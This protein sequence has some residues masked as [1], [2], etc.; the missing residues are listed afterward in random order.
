MCKSLF[1]RLAA[2]ILCHSTCD[3]GALDKTFLLVG[4]GGFVGSVLRYWLA[5]FIG[6]PVNSSFPFGTFTVNI[7]GCLLIGVI[8]GF[9]E[10]GTILSPEI[11]ILL[12]AGFCGGFTTFSAFS[13][14]SIS[15]LREG[16][17]VYVGANVVLSV[18]LGIVSTYIGLLIARSI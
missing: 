7:I 9:S 13:Y 12:T 11:R 1:G 8:A 4:V 2:G 14:E 6:R 10:R 5:L 15:L 17:L 16:E 18:S 3:G